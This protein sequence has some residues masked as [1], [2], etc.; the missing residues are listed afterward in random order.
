MGDGV[1]NWNIIYYDTSVGSYLIMTSQ[2]VNY[3]A[4]FWSVTVINCI[5]PVN[6]E[7]CYRVDQWLVPDLIYAWELKTGK[8]TPYQ[9]EKEYIDKVR[10]K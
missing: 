1:S 4:A 3:I 7:Y 8:V 10:N 6:W 5:Q 2:I 9:A